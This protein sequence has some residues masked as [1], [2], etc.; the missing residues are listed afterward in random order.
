MLIEIKLIV[1]SVEFRQMV[2]NNYLNGRLELLVFFLEL[3]GVLERSG[4]AESG[5]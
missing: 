1:E 3:F 2:I 4:N 5:A